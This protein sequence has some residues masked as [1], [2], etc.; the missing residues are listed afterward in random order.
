MRQ[1]LIPWLVGGLIVTG[2]SGIACAA[3]D[4]VDV[5]LEKLVQKG[6]LT[7]EE[8]ASV[9]QE[10]I[11][12]EPSEVKP[13]AASINE[14][15]TKEL[16]KAIL[17]K[18]V[19]NMTWGG[20]IRLREEARNGTGSGNDVNLQRIRF[21]L[22]VETKV[23]QD[24]LVAARLATGSSAD[25]VSTNQSFNTSFNRVSFLLDRAYLAYTPALSG[26]D[27]VKLTGGIIENPFWTVSEVV[28]DED[29]NF[30]G[31][32]MHVHSDLGPAS[33]FVN[34]GVF[35]LQ[36][37][38]TE[39]ASLWSIQGGTS[40]R[41]FPHSDD[42]VLNNSTLR[43]ALA[44]HDYKNVTNPLSESTALTTAGGL[45]GNT[46]G[47][48]DFNLMDASFQVASQFDWLPAKAW[49]EWVHNTAV[50]SGNNGFQV[51]LGVG[52]AKTPFDLKEGWE[53]AYY[54]ERLE[55]DA[56]F[57]AFAGSDFG[58]GGTNHRGNVWSIKLAVLK[59]SQLSFKYYSA[60]EVKRP[61]SHE[62][63]FQ[64]D[65]MTKF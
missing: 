52:K 4:K 3:K 57:G 48:Q 54:F 64:V 30:D 49:T 16:A 40:I 46:S 32:A 5:L 56:T 19:Q 55:P 37:A 24:L 63:R 20:D 22:G 38:I 59:N 10:V 62:D 42:D 50:E 34:A 26:I 13:V 60:E 25:P 35:S 41:P 44:Y 61:K 43:G 65:W 21:R 51:G 12:T 9:R 8:A 31:A 23:T 18:W 2:W 47:T 53:A 39:A 7:N 58:A 27:Q 14:A 11:E 45:K 1:R 29:L 36:T 15:Q 17:P 28:W 33:V 6:V